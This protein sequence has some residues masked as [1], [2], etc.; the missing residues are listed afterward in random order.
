V[1]LL[2]DLPSVASAGVLAVSGRGPSGLRVGGAGNDQV[3]NP[4]GAGTRGFQLRSPSAT[5]LAARQDSEV[6]SGASRGIGSP[7]RRGVWGKHARGGAGKPVPRRRE[8]EPQRGE[9][10]EGTRCGPV[11]AGSCRLSGGIKP[12]KP[13]VWSRPRPTAWEDRVRERVRISGGSKALKAE[14]HERCRGET[15]PTGSVGAPEGAER[16]DLGWRGTDPPERR[17]SL[18]A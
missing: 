3:E 11:S 16:D 13:T 5:V 8:G 1:W 4:R 17:G 12:P 7:V 2:R 18:K 6:R 10:Q 15:N 9:C 14:A